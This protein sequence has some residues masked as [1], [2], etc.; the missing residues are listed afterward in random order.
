MGAH[1]TKSIGLNTWASFAGTSDA[2]HVAGDVAMLEAE[3]NPVIR[4]LRAANIEVVAVHNHMLGEQPRMMFLHYY[5][6]GPAL[7]LAKGFRAALNQLGK[8][9]STPRG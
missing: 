5:G 4:E 8:H 7:T 1:I 3:V 2:A 6:R 9:Q